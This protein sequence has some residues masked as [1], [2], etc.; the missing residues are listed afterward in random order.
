MNSGPVELSWFTIAK[1]ILGSSLLSSFFSI[2]VTRLFDKNRLSKEKDHKLFCNLDY[3]T[4]TFI[5]DLKEGYSG[6]LDSVGRYQARLQL[7]TSHYNEMTDFINQEGRLLAIK[8]VDSL[9]AYANEVDQYYDSHHPRTKE[10]V[11]P[12]EVINN[13]DNFRKYMLRRA[14][15]TDYRVEQSLSKYVNDWAE[16]LDLET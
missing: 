9:F 11:S 1:I 12:K 10:L 4:R 5:N 7:L 2:V 8:L 13:Y 14:P 3:L 15:T 6:R 16:P